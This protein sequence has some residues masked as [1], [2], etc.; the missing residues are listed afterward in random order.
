MRT[1]VLDLNQ[2]VNLKILDLNKWLF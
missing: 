2:N 1:F